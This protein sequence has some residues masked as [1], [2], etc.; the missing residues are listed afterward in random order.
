MALNN[1]VDPKSKADWYTAAG[2]L[3]DL[4]G[5]NTEIS[6]VTPIPYFENL[7]PNLGSALLDDPS[8][9]A[10]QAAYA[11]VARE[12]VGGS[13]ILDWTYVQSLLDDLSS[14]GP[15]AFFHPQVAALSVFSTVAYSDYHAGALTIRQRL[16]NT[17]TYDF[18]YTLSKSID[19][20]SGLQNAD[21]YGSSFILNPLRP[22]DNRSVSD[23]D[24]R[25]IV[26]A[27]LIYEL[28]ISRGRAFFSDLPGVAQQIFGGWQLSNVF[29][30]NSGLPVQ[31]PFDAAQWATNWNVQ[32]NGVRIRPLQSSPTRGGTNA[33][34]LF[35]DPTAAYQG[36]RNARPGETGDRNVLR[37]PGYVSLDMG[38]FKSFTMPW[39]ENHN[40]QFRWEVFNLTNTQR[41]GELLG[42]RDGLGLGIDPDITEPASVFGNYIGI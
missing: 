42:G 29:R 1:L 15:N 5:R 36:F 2:Q 3:D 18:N 14:A 30:W 11:L 12:E 25:H 38:L 26:N 21:S 13:N 8:L 22:N 16:G 41:M 20:A 34:N 31:T 28:P 33:A 6:A 17:L 32:S 39:S 19:N 23:F 4:R 9:S 27:N 7:F 37:N 35:A 10:T 24:V 40:L